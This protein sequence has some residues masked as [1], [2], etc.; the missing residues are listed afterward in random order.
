MGACSLFALS[1]FLSFLAFSFRFSVFVVGFLRRLRCEVNSVLLLP[2][3]H[4]LDTHAVAVNVFNSS[5]LYFL[6]QIM[7]SASADYA[8]YQAERVKRFLS[9]EASSDEETPQ[10]PRQVA[11]SESPVTPQPL[12]KHTQASLPVSYVPPS[13]SSVA[14][15]TMTRPSA[16][17]SE[18]QRKGDSTISASGVPVNTGTEGE[19]ENPRQDNSESPSLS[20]LSMYERSK[21]QAA[22]A[23][24]RI[25]KLRSEIEVLHNGDHTFRPVISRR[26][27]KLKRSPL[28]TVESAEAYRQRLR[29]HIFNSYLANKECTFRPKICRRSSKIVSHHRNLSG[30]TTVCERL[31]QQRRASPR[32][33]PNPPQTVRTPKQ[34]EEHVASLYDF[35]AKKEEL[36]SCLRE[37]QHAY[38]DNDLYVDS[39]SV[40]ARLYQPKINIDEFP[41]FDDFPAPPAKNHFAQRNHLYYVQRRQVRSVQSWFMLYSNGGEV[42]EAQ[43]LDGQFSITSRGG[44]V[45]QVLQKYSNQRSW[46]CDEFVR[47]ICEH[48]EAEGV[49]LWKFQVEV[50]EEDGCHANAHPFHP[51][52]DQ[53]SEAIVLRKGGRSSSTNDRLYFAAR[54]NQLRKHQSK[55]EEEQRWLKE[56]EEKFMK[57][58]RLQQEWRH[59]SSA[60]LSSKKGPS[61]ESVHER[62]PPPAFEKHADEIRRSDSSTRSSSSSSSCTKADSTHQRVV[63]AVDVV[64]GPLM[65]SEVASAETPSSTTLLV[66]HSTK[67]KRGLTK[68]TVTAVEALQRVL[69]ELE[70]ADEVSG[71]GQG[72]ESSSLGSHSSFSCTRITSPSAAISK[73]QHDLDREES[74]ASKQT[75]AD[76]KTER[77]PALYSAPPPSNDFFVKYSMCCYPRLNSQSDADHERKKRLKNLGRSLYRDFRERNRSK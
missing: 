19:K 30:A 71:D 67:K 6:C 48:G 36:L 11:M 15:Q 12:P 60:A 61:Q 33:S 27:M 14:V 70:C 74:P 45:L 53:V 64:E 17:K 73:P 51:T 68:S 77:S 22:I 35:Q 29:D 13:P 72:S 47:I 7:A 57:K 75:S 28:D 63:N 23:A 21:R 69:S 8:S 5:F 58:Q 34:I 32:K 1:S 55:L 42:L 10:R 9:Y 25:E 66:K 4:F 37:Q 56:E 31:Y 3:S 26:A 38:R 46:T 2:C 39:A 18:E 41:L 59:I 54:S 24:E 62:S 65:E 49:P 52:V 40:V 16:N 76:S 43:M 44:K 20:K 50:A